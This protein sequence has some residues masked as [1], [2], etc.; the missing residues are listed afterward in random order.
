MNHLEEARL[1]LEY[2]EG[3]PNQSAKMEYIQLARAHAL[4]A[5]A[6]PLERMNDAKEGE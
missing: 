6:E 1:Q 3:A 4:I 2:V 5:I